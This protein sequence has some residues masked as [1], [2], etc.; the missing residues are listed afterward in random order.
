MD[1]KVILVSAEERWFFDEDNTGFESVRKWLE[2]FLGSPLSPDESRDDFY[3]KSPNVN[4]GV[5]LRPY[6]KEKSHF[7]CKYIRSL[8]QR[9]QTPFRGKIEEWTKWS[10]EL[11]KMLSVDPKNDADWIEVKKVRYLIK[12]S[13]DQTPHRVLNSSAKDINEGC[14]VELTKLTANGK[15]YWT[16]GFE[17]FSEL[18]LERGNLEKSIS[19]LGML[20]PR[21]VAL[22]TFQMSCGYAEWLSNLISSNS[23]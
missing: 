14:N 1:A 12:I 9:E 16:F 22:D 4:I 11:P 6:A 10:F 19:I 8:Q 20:K 15:G 18:Q 17:A 13:F 7:E 5:K 3:L 23:T 2:N 21:P